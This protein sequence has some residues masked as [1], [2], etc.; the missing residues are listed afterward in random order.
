MN[1]GE[2]FFNRL[3]ALPAETAE[4]KEIYYL[5]LSLGFQG[6]HAFGDGPKQIQELRQKLFRQLPLAN[7]SDQNYLNLFPEAYQQPPQVAAQR[8]PRRIVLRWYALALLLPATLF[9]VYWIILGR[10]VE[11]KMRWLDAHPLQQE[12]SQV[13][14]VDWMESLLGELKG[15]GFDV[16]KTSRGVVVILSTLFGANE[17]SLNEGERQRIE[18]IALAVN[19][20]PSKPS[21]LVEGHSSI[22]GS[23]LVNEQLSKDRAR[24]VASFLKLRGIENV[25]W[26]GQGSRFPFEDP[27]RSR[28]VEII[29]KSES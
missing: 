6:K 29:I 22:E 5:C 21:I 13:S 7:G 26:E 11:E 10:Q 24:A 14:K 28:R 19:R 23:A 16:R 27:R 18:E 1:A 8:K 2:D 4:L 9:V 3:E 20:R 12:E 17:T 25:L 15:R